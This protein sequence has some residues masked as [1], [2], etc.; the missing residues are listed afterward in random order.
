V[1]SDDR[2]RMGDNRAWRRKLED[3]RVSE[4][5]RLTLMSKED[6]DNQLLIT[7]I[8]YAGSDQRLPSYVVVTR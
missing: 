6:H 1:S 8:H 2:R 3:D 7:I 5:G 4:F